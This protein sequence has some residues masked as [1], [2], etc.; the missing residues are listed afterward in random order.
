MMMTR[1]AAATGGWVDQEA[2]WPVCRHVGCLSACLQQLT[3]LKKACVTLSLLELGPT[4]QSISAAMAQLE[5]GQNAEVCSDSR[6]L[7]A[8]LPPAGELFWLQLLRALAKD[9]EPTLALL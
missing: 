6:G 8:K 5:L 1:T 2:P 3:F 9:P 7:E 4:A